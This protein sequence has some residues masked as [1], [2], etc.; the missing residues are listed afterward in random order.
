MR[1]FEI[2]VFHMQDFVQVKNKNWILTKPTVRFWLPR[3]CLQIFS[4]KLPIE[5]NTQKGCNFAL[6][7]VKQ[8]RLIIDLFK[9]T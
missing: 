6:K 9:R 3:F 5:K 2:A 7:I 1:S 4:C 8:V